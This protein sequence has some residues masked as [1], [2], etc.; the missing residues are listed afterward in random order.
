MTGELA[1]DFFDLQLSFAETVRDLSGEPLETAL[2]RHTNLYVRFGFGRDFDAEH[3]G[4][5]RY[6]AGLRRAADRGDWTY[7]FHLETRRRDAAPR[8]LATFGCFSYAR[9]DERHVRLHFRNAE[10]GGRSPLGRARAQRRRRELA[11]LFAHLEPRV[12]REAPVVG[13]SWLYNLPAYRRLFPPGYLSSARP[14]PDAFHSMALWGQFL[15]R[16]G[17]VRARMARSFLDA[18]AGTSQVVDLG[19]CFPFQ[20]LR[21]TAPVGAFRAFYRERARIDRW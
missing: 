7:R 20:A 3:E 14:V 12:G 5:R 17:R 11:A 13:A 18:L 19:R 8:V 10:P 4:W 16:R 2:L 1:R 6:L 9:P 15:D 21:V